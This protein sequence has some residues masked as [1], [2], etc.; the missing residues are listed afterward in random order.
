MLNC[1]KSNNPTISLA[2]KWMI[3]S[4]TVSGCANPANDYTQAFGCPGTISKWC[5]IYTFNSNGTCAIEQTA[6]S[7]ENDTG[8][9]KI[10]GNL[11]SITF[12][13]SNEAWNFVLSGNNLIFSIKDPTDGCLF[14]YNLIKS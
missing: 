12:T 13:G 10:Y 8:T 5:Y 4:L 2:G 7:T 14:T 1:S 9:Y 6:T 11:V 3:T